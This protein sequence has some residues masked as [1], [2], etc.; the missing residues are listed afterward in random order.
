MIIMYFINE[1]ISAP[2][3]DPFNPNK[4][5]Y[6]QFV[7]KYNLELVKA[8]LAD[9]EFP[10][11]NI[12]L[13]AHAA[14]NRNYSA[15]FM[16]AYE[17][18]VN[19]VAAA[20]RILKQRTAQE[21]QAANPEYVARQQA[22]KQAVENIKNN[23]SLTENT[24]YELGEWTDI[25]DPSIQELIIFLENNGIKGYHNLLRRCNKDNN[26]K[27]LSAEETRKRVDYVIDGFKNRLS[28]DDVNGLMYDYETNDFS[29]M[30]TKKAEEIARVDTEYKAQEERNAA[31][32]AQKNGLIL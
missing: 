2:D 32:Q 4:T 5:R 21:T 15:Q 13:V 31:I 14:Y 29:T 10:K 6:L 23:T 27:K 26:D 11:E 28:I 24:I 9:E 18:D 12:H 19:I 17:Q 8:L 25:A 1:Q 7:N 20:E 22:R 16:K 3:F 30:E